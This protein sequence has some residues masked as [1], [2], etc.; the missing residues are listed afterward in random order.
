MPYCASRFHIYTHKV[1]S[2]FHIYSLN[3]APYPKHISAKK[4]VDS[5]GKK[6]FD[7]YFTFSFVR[8]P[9]DWQ[10]SLY[11]Y[12]LAHSEHRDHKTVKSL[13]NFTN[14]VEWRYRG[15]IVNQAELL[16]INGKIELNFI[17]RFENLEK[18]FNELCHQMGIRKQLPHK[19]YLPKKPYQEYYNTE[20][21]AMMRELCQQDIDTFGYSFE[22]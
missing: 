16:Q 6:I 17:G 13:G 1:L 19:N 11:N 22:N 2:L 9:W 4:L 18:D 21:S 8:N 14:Y 5:I 15:R 20:T 3:P 12:M 10:V 7:E